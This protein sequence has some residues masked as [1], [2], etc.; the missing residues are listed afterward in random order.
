MLY[1]SGEK[2]GWGTCWPSIQYDS[3]YFQQKGIPPNGT[4]F[5]VQQSIPKELPAQLDNNSCCVF[6]CHYADTLMHHKC[7]WGWGTKN[8]QLHVSSSM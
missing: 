6:K 5:G 2:P 3:G 1:A 8:C 7:F 4:M